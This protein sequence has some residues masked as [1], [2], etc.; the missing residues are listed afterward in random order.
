M[1]NKLVKIIRIPHVS[2]HDDR[3]GRILPQSHYVNSYGGYLEEGMWED[4]EK[5]EKFN[6]N[7]M[8]RENLD[9][10]YRLLKRSYH[11]CWQFNMKTSK[12]PSDEG[13]IRSLSILGKRSHKKATT[14]DKVMIFFLG[15][16][17]K[18]LN[19]REKYEK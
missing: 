1:K 13:W 15:L 18:Y 17:A 5:F 14:A 12:D 19:M 11:M 10:L 8:S 9:E 7:D 16:K 4:I 2:Q 6:E 3:W